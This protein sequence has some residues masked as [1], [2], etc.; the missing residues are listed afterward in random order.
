MSNTVTFT[1]D[2]IDRVA[3]GGRHLRAVDDEGNTHERLADHVRAIEAMEAEKRE[4]AASIKD[5]YTL[6]ELDGFDK[7][8]LREVIRRRAMDKDERELLE[9][10]VH[11]YEQGL[12]DLGV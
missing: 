5:R 10:H 4:I 1:K 8:A 7:K 11:A 2:E 12:L 3:Q 6:A 9:M